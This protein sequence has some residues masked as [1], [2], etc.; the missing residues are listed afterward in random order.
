MKCVIHGG[1]EIVT[2]RIS[3]GGFRAAGCVLCLL[4]FK[5]RIFIS[6]KSF[7]T[8]ESVDVAMVAEEW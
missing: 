2:M 1:Q 4:P 8:K 5:L 6:S 7:L 3:R